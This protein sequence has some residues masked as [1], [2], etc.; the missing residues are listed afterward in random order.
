MWNFF[1]DVKISF[2]VF[3]DLKNSLFAVSFK[4]EFRFPF[5]ICVFEKI[6]HH[7]IISPLITTFFMQKNVNITKNCYFEIV[8]PKTWI[9]CHLCEFQSGTTI[10]KSL[11]VNKS[12]LE[13]YYLIVYSIYSVSKPN[14]DWLLNQNRGN[15]RLE[16]KHCSPQTSPPRF[17][18]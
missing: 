17:C 15:T 11:S 6:K 13:K 10:R 7:L 14:T 1:H 12:L 4:G 2:F 16:N 8:T 3:S 18:R 5:D 9:L